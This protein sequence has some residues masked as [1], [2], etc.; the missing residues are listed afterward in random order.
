ML[1]S[2]RRINVLIALGAIICFG[3]GFTSANVM[4]ESK[5]L[6]YLVH[7]GYVAPGNMHYDFKIIPLNDGDDNTPPIS[8]NSS[9]FS[10][11]VVDSIVIGLRN[12]GVVVW[13]KAEDAEDKEEGK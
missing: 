2:G 4:K 12:D 5:W 3:L 13:K 6:G 7:G 10:P 11:V 1:Q 9:I 8:E